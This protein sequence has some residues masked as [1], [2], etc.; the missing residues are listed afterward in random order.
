MILYVM[1]WEQVTRRMALFYFKA[2]VYVLA[3][4]VHEYNNEKVHINIFVIGLVIFF[5][6]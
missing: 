3:S 4:F 5:V 1:F 2:K 6:I